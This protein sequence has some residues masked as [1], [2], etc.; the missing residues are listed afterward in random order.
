M[1]LSCAT[2]QQFLPRILYRD[3][4]TFYEIDCQLYREIHKQK[5]VH[6]TSSRRKVLNIP[7]LLENKFI[8][9]QQGRRFNF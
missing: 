4:Q 7:S 1:I 8:K 5:Y 6:A 2:N 9:V 3:N